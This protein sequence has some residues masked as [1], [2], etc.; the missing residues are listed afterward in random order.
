M[1]ELFSSTPTPRVTRDRLLSVLSVRAQ[2]T[3]L[4]GPARFGKTMLLRQWSEARSDVVWVTIHPDITTVEALWTGV[5]DALA[6]AGHP[7]PAEQQHR[8]VRAIAE[9]CL[10]AA[11]PVT[12]VLD[13]IDAIS[14]S[15][16]CRGLVELAHTC[17]DLHL[18]LSG[19]DLSWLCPDL[20]AE[21]TTTV[22]G[23]DELLFT[24]A[25]TA[26]LLSQTVPMLAYRGSYWSEQVQRCTGG[27]PGLADVVVRQMAQAPPD[28]IQLSAIATRAV[29]GHLRQWLLPELERADAMGLAAATAVTDHFSAQLAAAVTGNRDTAAHLEDLCAR[30]LLISDKDGGSTIYRWPEA[31]RCVLMDDLVS[32]IPGEVASL[33]SRWAT[34]KLRAGHPREAVRHA[35][36]ARDWPLLVTVLETAWRALLDDGGRAA[37][38]A[39]AVAP[40]EA[41]A[42]SWRALALRQLLLTAPGVLPAE[43][44]PSLP[45]PP[46][47]A[48]ELAQL[49]AGEHLGEVLDTGLLV[50]AARRH[51]GEHA[52]ELEH[53]RRLL[54][55]A[56]RAYATRPAEVAAHHAGIQLAVGV[57]LMLTGDSRAALSALDDAY[58]LGLARPDQDVDAS[59]ASL[60]ALQCAV[61]GEVPAARRWLARLTTTA[62]MQMAVG[63]LPAVAHICVAAA[64]AEL[65]VAVDSAEWEAAESASRRLALLDPMSSP[66]LDL[67]IYVLYAQAQYALHRGDVH[68]VLDQIL[69][70]RASRGRHLG[71]DGIADALLTRLQA[72]LLLAAGQASQV[73]RLLRL[74]RGSGLL[75]VPAARLALL[76]G[77]A[78]AS[79]AITPDQVWESSASTRDR[80]QMWLIQAIADCRSGERAS[81]SQSLDRAIRSA[82]EAD[83]SSV[84]ST[85]S[86]S[87]LDELTRHAP[88]AST[89]PAAARRPEQTEV[90][91][92]SVVL[93]DLTDREQGVLE[94]LGAGA[95][96]ETAGTALAI[97]YN[98][99]KTHVASI[100]RKL[101][102]DSRHA[103]IIEA[104]RLG[105]IDPNPV[106]RPP[107]PVRG[108]RDIQGLG[109]R[110]HGGALD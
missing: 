72:D 75:R 9:R 71:D 32:R 52:A 81:A 14:A 58:R 103:A 108:I 51:Q 5:I 85:V 25:E 18:V 31:A 46:N 33:H 93:T 106:H 86:A 38:E 77:D 49:A 96:L 1:T 40:L 54:E 55:I 8:S 27:W 16:F 73:Q 44:G 17:P 4:H 3:L 10:Q 82:R 98:T 90:Y 110:S 95:T 109:R 79:S 2:V 80:I 20:L 74:H 35:A 42:G 66:W 41:L 26:E 24:P 83:L 12:V 64:A 65:Q 104:Q 47:S 13:A 99:V 89:L 94:Q 56:A 43:D 59:A 60:V 63:C 69:V 68:A 57:G 62:T 29:S 102:V 101:G 30:G 107:R 50:I 67:W 39:L 88:A 92:R 76:S 100:Y 36:Q 70:A 45:F 48:A 28:P 6:L 23:P 97:S 37:R 11:G 53:A 19:R 87:D 15:E 21:V 78:T 105:L 34:E 7:I 84:W 61:L 91:P 22:I